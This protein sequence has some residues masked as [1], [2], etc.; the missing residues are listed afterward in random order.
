MFNSIFKDDITGYLSA[1]ETVLS[2]SA[3][4]N[5]V[6]CLWSFDKFLVHIGLQEKEITEPVFNGWQKT[7]A[8]KTITRACKIVTVRTFVKYLRSLGVSVY[9]PV[10]PK[11][12]DSYSPYIFTDEELSRILN[13]AG[14]NLFA[15]KQQ[16]PYMKTEFPMIL[17]L[18]YGC[19]LRIG[20]TLALQMKDIDLEGGILTL[21]HAKN[22]KHR[23][24]PMSRSLTTIMQRYCLAMGITGTPEAFLFPRKNPERPIT[25]PSVRYRFKTILKNLGIA[26]PNRKRR[27]RG[28]CQHCLR[29]VFVFKSFAQA[30]ASGR[31]IDDSVP[32]LSIFLGHDSLRETEKYLKFSSELF[33]NAL[34]LFEQYA[35]AAFPEVVYEK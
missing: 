28:P 29:H 16:N 25:I 24:V 35:G 8:G 22:G 5:D 15:Q 20:E 11:T 7:L 27:E 17:R 26:L 3:F 18:L 6:Y 30:Q 4:K 2:V 1:R 32:F 13:A 31:S 19:G 10:V 14:R 34:E 33:P 23:L 9:M 12:V 21:L